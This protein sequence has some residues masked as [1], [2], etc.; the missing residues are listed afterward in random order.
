MKAYVGDPVALNIIKLLGYVYI[1]VAAYF[2]TV[3]A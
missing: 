2:K 3:V 1:Y